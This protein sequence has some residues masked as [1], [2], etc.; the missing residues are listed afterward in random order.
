[1]RARFAAAALALFAAL[2]AARALVPVP[3]HTSLAI[4]QTYTFTD[5][6]LR[7]IHGILDQFQKTRGPQIQLL[8]VDTLD[9]ENIEGFA[10]RVF[11]AWKLGDAKRDDGILF[12]MALKDRQLRIEVGQ[13]LEGT[14]PDALAGR[15][16]RSDVIPEFK[17]GNVKGGV[18]AGLNA[19]AARLGSEL[20]PLPKAPRSDVSR[21]IPGVLFVAFVLF[22]IVLNILARIGSGPLGTRRRWG[23]GWGGPWGGGG[24]GWGGGGFGGGF[25]GGG[26]GMSSGG[27]ASGRW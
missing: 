9:G 25:G 13:G 2:P 22:L 20:G 3:P 23:G 17:A 7:Q 21:G 11:D 19:I 1:M 18:I 8:M 4:D 24:G 16:I 14:L 26:G 6:E 27:G 5:L 10:I 15:I 12:V